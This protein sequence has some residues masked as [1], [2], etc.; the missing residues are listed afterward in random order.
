MRNGAIVAAGDG[1]RGLPARGPSGMFLGKK[2]VAHRSAPL[3]EHELVKASALLRK[4]PR[5]SWFSSV[6]IAMLSPA[7]SI[8]W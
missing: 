5:V 3:V 1:G 7:A 2:K 4:N 8:R 6:S